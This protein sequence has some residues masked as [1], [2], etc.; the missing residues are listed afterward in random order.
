SL[1]LFTWPGRT[2][3]PENSYCD[4]CDYREVSIGIGRDVGP[5]PDP[6]K[7]SVDGPADGLFSSN[8][9]VIYF[10]AQGPDGWEPDFD[11]SAPD[12]TFIDPPYEPTN[13]YSLTVARAGLPVTTN[14]YPVPPQRIATSPARRPIRPD[15]TE[16]PVARVAGR[17]HYEQDAE[18]W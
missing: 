18:Y 2:V 13:F 15:G 4:S 17:V 1:R 3:L 11:A 8:N 7:P 9:D 5:P 16:T 12:T 6:T 10:F 14:R